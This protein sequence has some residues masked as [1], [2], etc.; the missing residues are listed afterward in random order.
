M[1]RNIYLILIFFLLM[2]HHIMA[3][4]SISWPNGAKAA[5]CLTYDDAI[6]TH[7]DI[8][9][10]DLDEAGLKGTFFMEG[11][12]IK[13]SRIADWRAASAEGHEL[14]SHTIFHSC[15]EQL[16]FI[17]AEFASENYTLKRLFL[18]LR[19]LNS[20]LY[21]IDGK[22][23]R[24]F[25]YPC[26]TTEYGGISIIDTLRNSG[27]YLAARGTNSGVIKDFKNLDLFRVPCMGKVDATGEELIS[28]AE[29]A[30]KVG[31]LTVFIF[32][33][34][35][36]QYL[37]VSREAHRELLDFLVKNKKIYWVA[38]FGRIMQYIKQEREKLGWK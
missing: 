15:S 28:Y 35:G 7:L 16:D 23:S 24:T 26:G 33:G 27:L 37:K 25:A 18:E 19:V 11:D 5:I 10:P 36:G 34:V 38:S 29:E 9:I 13:I 17:T 14:A 22:T 1:K 4:N 21:A 32:H 30:E 6:D 12:N 31:G 20:F 2:S 3:Q 8:V